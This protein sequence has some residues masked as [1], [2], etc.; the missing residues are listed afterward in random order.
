[1]KGWQKMIFDNIEFHGVD[2]LTDAGDGSYVL[3][4]AP[5]ALEEHL[6]E[7]G[8]NMNR[9]A[10]GTEL[11]FVINGGSARITLINESPDTPL[12]FT[13]F[14]GSVTAGWQHIR[15]FVEPGEHTIE[16]PAPSD[17]FREA[18]LS[19]WPDMLYDPR[20]VRLVSTVGHWRY[21]KAE[22]D[23]EPP[24]RDMAPRKTMWFYGSS[25]THGSLSVLPANS[26]VVRVAENF[27]M[28]YRNCGYAGNCRVEPEIA[29]CLAG[30][31][32][33]VMVLEMGINIL[34]MD[35]AEYEKRVRYALKRI[36][37]DNPEKPVIAIDVFFCEDDLRGG[38]H[39]GRF[40][41]ILK[42]AVSEL[43]LPNLHYINGLNIL[44]NARGLS[45]D[46]V[47]PS[48]RGV[49][50]IASNLTAIMKSVI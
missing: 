17:S 2:E 32:F 39:A 8:V 43:A 31:N 22:G 46:L 40:R 16:V 44:P 3:H 24:A 36:A 50:T 49:E 6:S 20:M 38:G 47:H 35:P 28:D 11:R 4:R 48:P 21:V 27:G 33:S 37:G 23:I 30:Q 15:K 29:D 5:A 1:M 18:I 45:G 14:Y 12:M 42:R 25:I 9:G 7:G 10:T 13:V 26:F 19:G 41:A 34:G